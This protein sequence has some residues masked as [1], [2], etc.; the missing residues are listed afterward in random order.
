MQLFSQSLSVR[1]SALTTAAPAETCSNLK[2]PIFGACPFGSERTLTQAREGGSVAAAATAVAAVASVVACA[3]QCWSCI[4]SVRNSSCS[5]EAPELPRLSPGSG[6]WLS[7]L[8]DQLFYCAVDK[9]RITCWK[10]LSAL[11]S[12]HAKVF[13]GEKGEARWFLILWTWERVRQVQ[14]RSQLSDSRQR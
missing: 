10:R 7:A 14:D 2:L 12:K 9:E 11:R 4:S 13:F 8:Q 1:L 6:V 5:A 3:V